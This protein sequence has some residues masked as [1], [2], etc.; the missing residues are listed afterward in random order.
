MMAVKIQDYGAI[1]SCIF[2]SVEKI[3]NWLCFWIDKNIQG[4]GKIYFG[5]INFFIT[6]L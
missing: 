6:K 3:H 1:R 4:G 2:C 5:K